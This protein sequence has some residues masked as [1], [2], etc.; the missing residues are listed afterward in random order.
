MLDGRNT[1]E[2][3]A[4]QVRAF[5]I[6]FAADFSDGDATIIQVTDRD[7][8]PIERMR[9]FQDSVPDGHHRVYLQLYF[10]K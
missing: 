8:N 5:I 6:Q 10:V 3:T 9:L 7:G 4:E 1:D 2:A